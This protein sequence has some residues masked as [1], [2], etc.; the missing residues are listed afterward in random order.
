MRLFI[1]SRA[2]IMHYEQIREEFADIIEGRWVQEE[3]LH[4][5]WVFLGERDDAEEILQRLARIDP[6]AHEVSMKGLGSFGRP[7]K[8]L[9]AGEKRPVFYKKASE[10]RREGFE[11]ERF[12]PHITLCRI[13]KIHDRE[14]FRAKIKAFQKVKLALVKRE[15]DLYESQLT[16]GGAVYRRIV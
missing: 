10:F 4:L 13:K 12:H 14:A 7:P 8:I 1:A 9:F 11:M 15:I 5:T 3:Q 16:S 2:V 6:L